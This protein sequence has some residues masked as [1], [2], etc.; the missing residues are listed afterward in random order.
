MI[1]Q[2]AIVK[3]IELAAPPFA[4]SGIRQYLRGGGVPLARPSPNLMLR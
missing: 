2:V 1:L 3:I 4:T